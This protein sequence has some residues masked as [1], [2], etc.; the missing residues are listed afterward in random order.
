MSHFTFLKAEWPDVYEAADEGRDVREPGPADGVLL[1]PASAGTCSFTGSTSTRPLCNLPYQDNLSALI[2]EPTFKKRRGRGL[3]QGPHYHP[4]RQHRR[5]QSQADSQY[6]A[7]MA[8]KELFHVGYWLAHTYAKGPKP[9]AGTIFNP[10]AAAQRTAG[11]ADRRST[12]FR[13]S[14]STA[15]K[16]EKLSVAARRQECA[17]RRAARLRAEIA[18]DEEGQ[19]CPGRTTTTTPKPRPATPSS[20]CCSTRPAGR[21]TRADDREFPVTGMPNNDGRGLRRLRAVGRRRQ[22]ARAGR[23]QAHP[24]DP[25]VGQQ[26]AKLY[27]D[28]L[29][30]R[31]R[32]AAGDLLHQRL[33]ALDLGR[34]AL[35]AARRS[36]ASTRRTSWSC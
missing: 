5:P 1:R 7:Q 26:Q 20:T 33:R 34:H 15:G 27:A 25:R 16:D 14:K 18:D 22:A 19:H 13:N 12:S 11:A 35:P 17:R 23:G 32:P 29:E 36:R 3:Q 24:Q 28:C 10:N 9:P 21:S 8:V 31:V 6:D 4:A 2:H 30:K